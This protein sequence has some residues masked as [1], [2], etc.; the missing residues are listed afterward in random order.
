MNGVRKK[1]SISGETSFMNT[2]N[3]GNFFENNG[4]VTSSSGGRKPTADNIAHPMM[5]SNRQTNRVNGSGS[6]RIQDGF[7][8]AVHGVGGKYQSVNK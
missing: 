1:S 2:S 4:H 3:L 5:I 8:G 7:I 6:V